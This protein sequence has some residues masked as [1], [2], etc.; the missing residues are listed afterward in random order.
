MCTVAG[1]QQAKKWD[2]KAY[3]QL[4]DLEVNGRVPSCVFDGYVYFGLK[5]EQ[6]AL[7]GKEGELSMFA[8]LSDQQREN[9]AKLRSALV[10]M[11]C[12]EESPKTRVDLAI[13]SENK[14]YMAQR[15][16]QDF[17]DLLWASSSSNGKW[18]DAL[19]G[20]SPRLKW[21]SNMI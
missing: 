6:Y 9:N 15:S 16:T 18:S 2:M 11:G 1:E 7:T 10:L 20:I 12:D 21:Y 14:A 4:T 13:I 3:Q 5:E 17:L 8:L 19:L